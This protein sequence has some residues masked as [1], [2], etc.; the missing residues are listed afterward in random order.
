[1]CFS[2]C[3]REKLHAAH[4]GIRGTKVFHLRI[5]LLLNR[6]D[7]GRRRMSAAFGRT[8]MKLKEEELSARRIAEG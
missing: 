4:Y 5:E 2:S 1:M 8:R 6:M 7:D 3:V